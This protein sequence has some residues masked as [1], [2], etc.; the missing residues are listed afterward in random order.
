MVIGICS[1]SLRDINYEVARYVCNYITKC[2]SVP[3]FGEEFKDV[4][5]IISIGGDGTLLSTIYKYRNLGVPFVGINKG[6]IGFLTDIELDRIDE[7][8]SNI[9]A[10]EYKVIN[11]SQL[12]V[13][14]YDKEG[15]L[16]DSEVCLNDAV[17]S[18]GADLHVVNMDVFIN[19][20]PVERF[21]GDG[22]IVST[23]TGSTAYSLAAGG[24]I[25]TPSMEDMI[26]TPLCPHTLHRQSYVID[27]DSL[28]EV[29]LGKFESRPLISPDGRRMV[30]LEPDDVICISRYDE[31]VK[32]IDM[33]FKDF[34]QK[35]NEKI[36]VRGSFY[37][38][39]K[40]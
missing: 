36:A 17:V 13:E 22:L 7:A 2:G 24:P 5:L 14:I 26:I 28:I 33:G 38:N 10:Q 20:K 3:I 35:V 39:S 16:K 9:L 21:V 30:D 25:L 11:R 23:A 32:T 34:Y 12:F 19:G 18:R 6:S 40:K 15:N 31:V 29:H 4:D 8:L 37:E 27:R 1:N